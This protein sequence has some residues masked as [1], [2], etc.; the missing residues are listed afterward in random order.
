MYPK[1]VLKTNEEKSKKQV[2]HVKKDTVSGHDF[3]SLF[4]LLWCYEI[5]VKKDGDASRLT[6][7]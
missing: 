6:K 5:I 4:C 1:M 7:V 3:E 2:H